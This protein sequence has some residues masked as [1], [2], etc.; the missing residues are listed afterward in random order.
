MRI[1]SEESVE[2]DWFWITRKITACAK[3]RKYYHCI[4]TIRI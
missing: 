1:Q 2:L 4:G 3:H